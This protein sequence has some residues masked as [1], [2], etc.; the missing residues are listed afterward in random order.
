M[1]EDYLDKVFKSLANPVRRSMLDSLRSGPRTTGELCD[2]FPQLSRY[3][4]M[5]HLNVLVASSLVIVR[6]RGRHRFNHLNPAP[7]QALHER[8]ITPFAEVWSSRALR[9]K[10]HIERGQ[11][12]PN[13]G[14]SVE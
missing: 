8:W 13:M 14:G 10:H 5:K 12:N 3:A 1:E 11:D 4:V 2:A 6:R 7:I 9:L